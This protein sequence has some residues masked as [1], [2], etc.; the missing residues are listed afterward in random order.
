MGLLLGTFIRPVWSAMPS[1]LKQ[2]KERLQMEWLWVKESLKNLAMGIKYHWFDFKDSSFGF[3]ERRQIARSLHEKMYTAF[4]RGDINT[5]KKICCTGLVNDLAARI[6]QRRKDEKIIWTL[7]KY[8]RGPSTYFTGVRIMADRAAAIP[9]VPGTGIRQ[10][11]VRITSRQ[12]KGRTKQP[13]TK[14]SPAESENSPTAT[15]DCTEHIVLQRQRVFGQEEPWRIWGHVTP[16]TVEDLDDPAFAAGLSV[17]ERF[18]AMR[19]LAG[20]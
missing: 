7:D 9:E 4:A 16:T 3:R 13:S 2:P 18:E 11:V 20:R 14:G 5:L 15:Q 12:S 8:H 10:V 17:A 19:N 6:Q 1:M